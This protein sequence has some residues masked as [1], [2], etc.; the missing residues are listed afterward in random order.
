MGGRGEADDDD[1]YAQP[2]G[3]HFPGSADAQVATVVGNSKKY[4]IK[5]VGISISCKCK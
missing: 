5:K 4:Q 2:V 3:S 1:R